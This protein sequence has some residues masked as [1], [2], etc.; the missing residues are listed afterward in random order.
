LS[1]GLCNR[2]S[3]SASPIQLVQQRQ[4]AL[5][6]AAPLTVFGYKTAERLISEGRAN[7]NGVSALYL[8]LEPETAVR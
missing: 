8:A 1:K 6:V 4:R 3:S 5:R 2:G 7:R